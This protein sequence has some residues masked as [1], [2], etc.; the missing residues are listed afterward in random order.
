MASVETN[1]T[2]A[3]DLC[4]DVHLQLALDQPSTIV[5]AGTRSW[6]RGRRRT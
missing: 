6:M 2:A 1:K 4:E 3:R 5:R